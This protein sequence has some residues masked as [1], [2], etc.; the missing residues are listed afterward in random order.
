M[1][2]ANSSSKEGIQINGQYVPEKAFGNLSH[3]RDEN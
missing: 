2:S 1:G 3:P